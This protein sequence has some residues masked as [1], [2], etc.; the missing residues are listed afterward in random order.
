MNTAQGDGGVYASHS[1]HRAEAPSVSQKPG[2]VNQIRVMRAR[3]P[4]RI[5]RKKKKHEVAP[6]TRAEDDVGGDGLGTFK[7]M[8]SIP[9]NL[10]EPFL[11]VHSVWSRLGDQGNKATLP[12]S[13]TFSNQVFVL[14]LF[15]RASGCVRRA[16]PR[17]VSDLC[18]PCL[19]DSPLLKLGSAM[20]LCERQGSSSTTYSPSY[21]Y[22]Q[23]EG[24][25]SR[26]TT[27]GG[28][29]RASTGRR[30]LY[31]EEVIFLFSTLNPVVPL[32]PSAAACT[33]I[34]FSRI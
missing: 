29:A 19:Q 25:R 30:I 13:V 5:H 27:G 26:C 9:A 31:V 24:A 1:R 16:P 18:S 23:M 20:S 34:S 33:G 28:S 17:G 32:T 11:K 22:M 6:H 2:V 12:P 3:P 21:T 10:G 14:R 15:L 7:T 4:V 8:P